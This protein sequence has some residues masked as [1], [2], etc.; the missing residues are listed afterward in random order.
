MRDR[1][2]AAALTAGKY[3]QAPAETSGACLSSRLCS[4]QLGLPPLLFLT[5]RTEFTKTS[6]FSSF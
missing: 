6:Q 5:L 2:L 4:L 1:Q 3:I